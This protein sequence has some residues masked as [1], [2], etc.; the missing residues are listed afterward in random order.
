MTVQIIINGDN[1]AASLKE[2]S[3]LAAGFGAGPV[4]KTE[5]VP[6]RQSRTITKPIKEEAAEEKATPTVEDM[7][8]EPEEDDLGFDDVQIP[9]DVQLRAAAS[10][11]AKSAGKVA[12]KALLDKYAVP[13]VTALPN[14]KR[15]AFMAELGELA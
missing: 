1:A 9:D 15:V 14:D 5:E 11:K 13:N 2:L 6:K 7:S 3:T 12:V 4:V 8:A 10:E